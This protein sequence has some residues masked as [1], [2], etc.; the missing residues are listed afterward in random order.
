M[1]VDMYYILYCFFDTFWYPSWSTFYC[2]IIRAHWVKKIISHN[3]K[4]EAW[5]VVSDPL[6]RLVRHKG[7]QMKYKGKDNSG[8]PKTDYLEKI[9]AMDADALLN[10]TKNKIWLSAYA[11]NN[12]CSDFHWQCDACYDECQQRGKPEI[13]QCAYDY[14][15]KNAEQ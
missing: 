10:E 15:V 5:R 13:Y 12:Q 14:H 7:Y 1:L 9:A 6:E 2:S 11:S 8:K 4:G 3:V